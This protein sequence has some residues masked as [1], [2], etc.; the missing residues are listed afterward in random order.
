MGLEHPLVHLL[1][2]GAFVYTDENRQP[3]MI[4]TVSN[5]DGVGYVQFGKAITLMDNLAELLPRSRFQPTPKRYREATKFAWL[6]PGEVV[7]NVKVGGDHGA[8]A[9]EIQT[10]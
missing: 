9:F 5:I 3:L 1:Q 10:E 2:R 6:L 4:N 8:F 7:S